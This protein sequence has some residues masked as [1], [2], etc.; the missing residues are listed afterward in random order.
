MPTHQVRSATPADV[1]QMVV[2]WASLFDEE[3]DRAGGWRTNASAWCA[4]A[5]EDRTTAHLPLVEADGAVVATAIGTLELGVPN[6]FCARGRSVRLANLVTVPAHRGR[7]FATLLVDDVVAWARSIDAD[8][9]DL[10]ATPD[11]RGIY[12]RAGFEPTT[13]PR[14]KLVLGTAVTRQTRPQM[15]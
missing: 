4:G 15:S 6:P 7:G 8:R 1:E 3:A 10:S 9:V 13:A 5:L 11:G 12:E 14:M 2:L